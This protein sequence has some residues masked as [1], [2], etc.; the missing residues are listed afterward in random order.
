MAPLPEKTTRQVHTHNVCSREVSPKAPGP[1]RARGTVAV[2]LCQKW[3]HFAGSNWQEFVWS[4]NSFA[5]G[6]VEIELGIWK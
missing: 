2:Q 5:C 6:G 4:V 3:L 1:L